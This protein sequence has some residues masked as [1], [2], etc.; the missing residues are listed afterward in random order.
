MDCCD[1][2]DFFKGRGKTAD[3]ADIVFHEYHSSLRVGI[4]NFL[5]GHILRNL[6]FYHVFTIFLFPGNKDSPYKSYYP[7]KVRRTGRVWD[8][9]KKEGGLF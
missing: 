1:I 5:N 4:N 9:A 2:L 6:V 7:G 8:P 3:A